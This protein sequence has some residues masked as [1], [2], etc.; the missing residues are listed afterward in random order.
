MNV[1]KERH[2]STIYCS[3]VILRNSYRYELLLLL[4]EGKNGFVVLSPD[5]SCVIWLDRP[6]AAADRLPPQLYIIL[7]AHKKVHYVQKKRVNP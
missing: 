5:I 2:S 7:L 6:V 3:I 1:L 4:W